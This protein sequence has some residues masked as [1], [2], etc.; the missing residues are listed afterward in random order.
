MDIYSKKSNYKFIIF[1]IAMIIGTGTVVYTNNLAN[2]IAKNEKKKAKLWADATEKRAQMLGYTY[3]LFNKLATDEREKVNVWAQSTKFILTVEDND[4]LTFFNEIV[5][6]NDNIP[7]LLVSEDGTVLSARN[8]DSTFSAKIDK[9]LSFAELRHFSNYP[10]II[11]QY[12]NIPGFSRNYIYYQDSKLFQDLRITLNELVEKFIYEV[13]MNTTSSPVIL[14]NEK[15]ELLAFSNIDSNDVR[16]KT[17]LE[18][19]VQEMAAKKEPILLTLG[20]NN[21]KYI[22]YDESLM[23]KQLRW[24]PFIQLAIFA[25][26]ILLSYL[27]FSNSRKAEQNLV[28]VGMAK[29]TAHQLGTPISS[30]SSWVEYMK[31]MK[32]TEN[33]EILDALDQDIQRLTLVAERF[34]KIGSK[35]K[36]EETNL[37][38]FVENT[39]NYFI[40]RISTK[41]K[42]E[43]IAQ[44]EKPILVM[45]NGDLFSWVL[46]N[47]FKNAIDAMSGEGKIT[48]KIYSNSN[49]AIIDFQDSGNGL[50]KNKWEKIFEPGYSTKRRGWGLGLSLSKRI[51]EDYHNGRIFVKHSEVGKGTTFSIELKG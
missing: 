28:W 22:Y 16:T 2:K 1:L 6:S 27:V 40:K 50:A 13:V 23:I 47:L 48:V 9:Q 25:A 42:V 29:E 21:K 26:F 38:E 36:L 11:V 20:N 39:A 17:K 37:I 3:E 44:N 19:K 43:V 8:T 33:T 12:R 5:T 4:L 7:V 32:L 15:N 49:K 41:V 14:L 51:V 35:P 18:H 34:S 10:P 45:L 24:F 46:E 30:L 31:E